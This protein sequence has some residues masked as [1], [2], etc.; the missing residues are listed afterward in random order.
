MATHEKAGGT[1]SWWLLP[2][3]C[4]VS[5]HYHVTYLAPHIH[6]ASSC[7]Q[8]WWGVLLLSSTLICPSLSSPVCTSLPPYEQLLVVE[9]SGAMGIIISPLSLSSSCPALAVL[10]LMLVLLVL[11]LVLLSPLSPPLP[12]LPLLAHHRQGD[13]DRPISTRSTLQ[14]RAGSSGGQVLG[15]HLIHLV[16]MCVVLYSSCTHD[17]PYK[18]LLIG[19]GWVPLLLFHP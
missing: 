17:P 7:L 8:W 2:L 1:L 11:V 5:Q 16:F 3:R 13:G 10:V 14:A 4:V 18:Q 9:G 6:P 12:S 15:C 19:M